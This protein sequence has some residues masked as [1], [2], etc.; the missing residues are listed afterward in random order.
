MATI[1]SAAPARLSS[2]GQLAGRPAIAPRY[3]PA[4]HGVGIVH[5]GI[6]A[7]HR[8]HQAVFTDDALAVSGG[9]WRIMGASLRSAA[10]AET[11]NPQN[12]LYTLITRGATGSS[13]R[14]IGSV[15][16][17]IVARPDS[18][19]LV[20][21]MARPATRIISLTVSEKA[22]GIDRVTGGADLHHPAV[23]ADLL[24]PETPIGV[25]GLIVTALRQRFAAGTA[26]F[27]VLCCDNLPDNGPLVRSGVLDFA[28]RIDR[29]L[30]D[31]IAADVAFPATMVDRI[32]PAAN[33]QTRA[34]A[35]RL[36]GLDDHAAI[37]TEPF[38]QW[39]IEDNFP[40]GRPNWEVGGAVFTTD[41]ALF[42]KMKLRMLNGSHSMLAYGGFL[43]GFAHVRDVMADSA[44][45]LLV[46]R[47]MTAAA[48]T[49][50]PLTGVDTGDYAAA[51]L[52]RFAN[53][54]LAHQ[55]AQ[56]AMDG[57]EKLPQRI[58]APAIEAQQLGQDITPFAFATAL[59][60]RFCLGR[61]DDGTAYQISDPRAAEITDRVAR[62]G[63]DTDA[64]M[65]GL[66]AM[67]DVFDP[68]FADAPEMRAAIQNRLSRILRAGTRAA[69]RHEADML[70]NQGRY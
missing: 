27:T 41:V 35:L 64:L 20:A 32:T 15:A 21:E 54:S 16:G 28:Q 68:A 55:T 50:P 49:L 29:A 43:S 37:E 2:F 7:F 9:D 48:A 14:V 3:D 56:I 62:A 45:S 40:T 4:A 6:G 24:A 39:V 22:Y 67:R 42:E 52:E 58:V 38:S 46:K 36:T 26:P 60:M 34:E 63:Q 10:V 19:Q 12:G 30:A 69:I 59:W 13:A 47:H 33:A 23:A 65:A 25:M 31:R 17:V 8:A 51:L 1:P 66:L 18:A 61:L 5:L 70:H 57:T 44:L 53:P 11:L